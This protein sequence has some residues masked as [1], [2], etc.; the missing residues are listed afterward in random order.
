MADDT[1]VAFGQG[2]YADDGTKLGTVRGFDRHGFYVT[3]GAGVGALSGEHLTA[4]NPGEAERMWRRWA[5][6]EMG[7]IKELP[8]ECPSCGAPKEDIYYWQE[9]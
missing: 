1:D 8:K 6:G 2:V 4:G 3:V 7:D 9:D 5:C